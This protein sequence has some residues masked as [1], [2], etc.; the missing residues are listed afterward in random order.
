MNIDVAFTPAEVQSLSTK[1]CVVIDVIR[2]T[3]TLT[4][5]MSRKPSKLILTTSVQKASKYASQQL[6]HPLL[7]GERDGIAPPGFDHGNSPREYL[8]LDLD[9]RTVVFTS[10]NGTRAVA[11]VNIAP[12]VF[13]GSFLNASATIEKALRTARAENLDIIIVCSGREEKFAID[14]AYCA[15]FMVSLIAAGIPSS[16]NFVLGDG[17]QAALAIYG[18]FRDPKKLFEGSGAGKMVLSR[19]LGADIDYLLQKSLFNTVPTLEKNK[20]EKPE[21]G[22]SLLL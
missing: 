10:S 11:D 3:S 18:Y 15:G 13:L 16:E 20:G 21:N 17:G 6:E 7:C 19:G 9:G 12:H 22:F 14:D 2:A 1:V 4:V 8:D 5:I